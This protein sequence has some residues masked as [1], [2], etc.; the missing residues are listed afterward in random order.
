MGN[1]VGRSLAFYGVHT[2]HCLDYN[3]QFALNMKLMLTC[4]IAYASDKWQ[5]HLLTQFRPQ[6]LLRQISHSLSCCQ[7]G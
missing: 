6:V 3:V 1:L 2:V 4:Y 5:A 7:E